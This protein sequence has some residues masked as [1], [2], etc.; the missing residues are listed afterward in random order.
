MHGIL[1]DN[2]MP[3]HRDLMHMCSFSGSMHTRGNS[4]L[5]KYD[6][7]WGCSCGGWGQIVR[8]GPDMVFFLSAMTKVE[9]RGAVAVAL[10]KSGSVWRAVIY[11]L[12]CCAHKVCSLCETVSEVT[13]FICSPCSR[14]NR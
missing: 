6:D 11:P 4:G 7:T 3:I 14:W 10:S 9:S 1:R 13:L 8:P 12:T 5:V 2:N